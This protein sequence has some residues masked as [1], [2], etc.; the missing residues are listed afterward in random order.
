M[1]SL[2]FNCKITE[3]KLFADKL[4]SVMFYP[5]GYPHLY[6]NGYLNQVEV[7]L[8]VIKSYAVLKFD[9]TI[10]NII[11]ENSTDQIEEEIKKCIFENYSDS[12]IILNFTRPSTLEEWKKDVK[13]SLK[14]IDNN[15][16]VLVVMNHDHPFVDYTPEVFN[17]V[18]ENIFIKTE[19]NFGKALF[20]S[21]AP[22]VISN[23][24]NDDSENR[25]TSNSKGIYKRKLGDG[26]VVSIWLMT[27]DTLDYL[28]S[29]ASS[30]GSTYMGR[31]DWDGIIYNQ[32]NITTYTFPREFFKHFDGYGHVTGIRLISD[33]R[34]KGLPV[35]NFSNDS[36]LNDISKF[37]YDRWIDCFLLSVR[38]T[39][40]KETYSF[41][42]PNKLYRKAINESLIL[43]KIG[44]LESDVKIGLI[45]ESSLQSIE[46]IIRNCIYYHGN[47]LFSIIMTDILLLDGNLYK[48]KNLIKKYI[49]AF[50]INALFWLK[51]TKKL[52]YFKHTKT[53][54]L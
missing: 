28:L 6:N 54:D 30:L 8:K 43:F 46:S 44:Y 9:F 31:I 14:I 47:E 16:P 29:K 4:D 48:S 3:Q 35:W 19:N 37:Y 39:L 51:K 21:H 12:R 23:I 15:T 45:Q 1:F 5:V 27:L 22:E 2:Y 24:I 32:L 34:T 53:L 49:P 25:R 17:S 36:H 13:D 10:F 52:N 11:I 18:L 26:S 33:I 38:D 41:K 42:S 50:I 40:R 7:L 20:Y